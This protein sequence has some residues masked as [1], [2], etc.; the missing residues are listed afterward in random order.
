MF[1]RVLVAALFAVAALTAPSQAYAQ[2]VAEASSED[3]ER[4]FL[5]WMQPV[6]SVLER[7]SVV[8][9]A[10]QGDLDPYVRNERMMQLAF[11]T[12]DR[13]RGYRQLMSQLQGELRAAPRF[14]HPGAPETYILMAETI[15]RDTGTY[16][17]N[18]DSMLGH[19]ISLVDAMEADDDD[20][21]ARVGPRLMQSAVLLLDGQIVTLRARQQL[22]RV[23]DTAYHALGAM[24]SLYDGMRVAIVLTMPD[25]AGAMIDTSH[26]AARWSTSGR[27]AVVAAR[28]DLPT[29]AG[30]ERALLEEM[31]ELEERFFAVNDRVVAALE[32]AARDAENRGVQQRLMNALVQAEADYMRINQRIIELTSDLAGAGV[33][34]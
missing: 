29:V 26:A 14:E 4:A 34:L 2:P 1:K 19:I 9:E 31:L 24:M 7:A 25:R 20:A 28:S 23:D 15:S 3:A 12:R 30:R 32:V 22:L 17:Q 18:M 5:V 11:T 10:F 33:E 8:N 6:L 27:E 21:V 16:L 13:A